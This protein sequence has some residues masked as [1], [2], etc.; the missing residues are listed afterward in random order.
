MIIEQFNRLIE[1]RT[2]L[3]ARTRFQ[4]DLQALINQLSGG[5][6]PGFYQTLRLGTLTDRAWQA[7]IQA[8]TIGETYFFRDETSFEFMRSRL[9]PDLIRQR[10]HERQLELKIW[11]A[12]CASGEEP[13]SVAIILLGILP[14]LPDWNIFLVATDINEQA[15]AQAQAGVYRDWAFRQPTRDYQLRYFEAAAEGWRIK[16]QVH[17]MVSFR[18]ASLL[19]S[20]PPMSF[21][22]ILC[23][24]VLIYLARS[25]IAALENSFFNALA[26]GGWLFLG[27]SEAIRSHR[28]RWIMHVY[29][30]LVC[31][32][33]PSDLEWRVTVHHDTAPLP[34]PVFE[35]QMNGSAY[36]KAVAAVHSNRPEE[37]ERELAAILAEQPHHAEAHILLAYILGSRRAFSEA[38]L[39]LD[40]VLNHNNLQS[41]AHYLRATLHFEEG[42]Y[43][44]AAK[45]LRA[46]LYCQRDH[47][48][49]TFMLG[50]LY[51]RDGQNS[52]CQP[53]LGSRP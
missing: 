16:P 31:Y 8:L 26:P 46:A 35:S 3:S 25:Q 22:L 27:S 15:L 23:R 19:D 28:E 6:L 47:L 36:R 45:S 17:D 21:D 10:R 13:Y 39:H 49:A 38:H 30:D 43:D 20:P 50:N 18:Q 34:P 42:D 5:D 40:D 51:A 7:V 9:L 2:G 52:A 32:Q 29:P 4:A 33:R 14:D 48:L 11:C 24:N 53:G 37:A 41:D 1:E 12:G 44:A